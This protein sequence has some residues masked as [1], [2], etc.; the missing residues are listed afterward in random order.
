[1]IRNYKFYVKIKPH[2]ANTNFL[3]KHNLLD[4]QFT[5]YNH[6]QKMLN[7]LHPFFYKRVKWNNLWDIWSIKHSFMT[8]P[9]VKIIKIDRFLKIYFKISEKTKQHM[10]FLNKKLME[11]RNIF[12][13]I[14]PLFIR[15]L[16]R[17][18]P[19]FNNCQLFPLKL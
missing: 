5:R 19:I 7:V 17:I 13:F 10:K 14:L 12:L 9:Q 1:M 16:S 3:W 8:I 15:V 6:S 4:L 11:L 2:L 18:T